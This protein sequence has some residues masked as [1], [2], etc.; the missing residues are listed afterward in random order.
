MDVEDVDHDGLPDSVK[1]FSG[2]VGWLADKHANP[3]LVT[4]RAWSLRAS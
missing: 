2:Q 1:T 4:H 3:F